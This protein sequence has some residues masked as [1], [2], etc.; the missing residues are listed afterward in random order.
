MG[1]SPI[2]NT[3]TLNLGGDRLKANIFNS[4]MALHEDSIDSTAEYLSM[5]RQTLCDKRDG[6]S[7]F[8]RDEITKII[9][10]WNLTAEEVF[11][12]FFSEGD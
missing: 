12:M 1:S 9:D 10:R 8:R 4:K 7:E 5:T 6:K 11:E 3:I 2:G